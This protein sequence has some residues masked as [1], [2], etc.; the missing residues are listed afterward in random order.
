MCWPTLMHVP[1]LVP[2]VQEARKVLDAVLAIQ[3]RVATTA[4]GSGAKST[5]MLALE[6]R[7]PL[8][9]TCAL[10]VWEGLI[11]GSLS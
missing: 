7:G 8:G 9:C 11:V 2:V 4:G 1:A 3:P 10:R 5:E 6:V